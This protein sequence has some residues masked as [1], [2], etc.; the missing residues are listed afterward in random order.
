MNGIE[1]VGENSN[2]PALGFEASPLFYALVTILVAI[3]VFHGLRSWRRRRQ[4]LRLSVPQRS[5]R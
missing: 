3:V 5:S 4:S 1:L 2:P